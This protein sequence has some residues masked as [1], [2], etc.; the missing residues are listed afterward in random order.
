MEFIY[1]DE[2]ETIYVFADRIKKKPLSTTSTIQL[3]SEKELSAKHPQNPTELFTMASG[4][5]I[6]STGATSGQSSLF[7]RGTDAS[8]TLVILDGM[9]VNDPSDP[10]RSFD[11]SQLDFSNI[12]K[13]EILKGS[14]TVLYGPNAVGGVILL[15]SKSIKK[16]SLSHQLNLAQG[17]YGN[18]QMGVNQ[19]FQNNWANSTSG[20]KWQKIEGLS[21]SSA[22]KG[23]LDGQQSFNA[24]SK[25]EFKLNTFLKGHY[26]VNW[27]RQKLELDRSAN[28]DDPNDISINSKFN[29]LLGFDADSEDH[30]LSTNIQYSTTSRVIEQNADET[31]TTSQKLK[32]DGALK[33][34]NLQH[35]FQHPFSLKSIQ[36]VEYFREDDQSQ[37]AQELSS[38]YLI[39]SFS[40]KPF[41]LDMG[42]RFDHP[43]FF[44]DAFTYKFAPGYSFNENLTF[45]ASISTAY[46]A[47]TLNQLF[48]PVYGNP[49]L[50]PEKSYNQEFGLSFANERFESQINFFSTQIKDR[51]TFHPTTYQNLNAG[52]A[53]IEGME[54]NQK[55]KLNSFHTFNS[56]LDLM[57]TESQGQKLIRRPA[58]QYKLIHQYTINDKWELA[59]DLKYVGQRDDDNN[60]QRMVLNSYVL[61]N[62][63]LNFK[64][65]NEQLLWLK[66]NNLTNHHYQEVY[67]Y[68]TPGINY[69]LGLDYQ[70]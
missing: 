3:I 39:E 67:G 43:Q 2:V 7:L 13:V 16:E 24:H 34:I 6:A 35:S 23:D 9:I 55:Y 59:S 20:F 15:T 65:E 41:L 51:L 38:L 27:M 54:L 5:N 28:V 14:Q 45:K 64:F 1:A 17:S 4:L 63:G 30:S 36:G 37:H 53:K 26:A 44:N 66:V 70:F 50:V 8:H 46:K 32:Y 52:E 47:P 49:N 62:L 68:N 19:S 31:Q 29:S 56:F 18:L 42:L 69:L 33:K 12:Q 22:N 61:F 60:G 40:P 48:T 25:A 10:S 57:R 11:F 58:I 21:A